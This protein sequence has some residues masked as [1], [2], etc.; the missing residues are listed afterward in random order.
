MHVRKVP[1]EHAVP[2]LTGKRERE[3]EI[4][5]NKDCVFLHT[6]RQEADEGVVEAVQ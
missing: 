6:D 3:K 1:R 5:R 4:G 2:H